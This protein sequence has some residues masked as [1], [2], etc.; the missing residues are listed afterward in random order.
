MSTALD[1]MTDL[2]NRWYNRLASELLADPSVAQLIQP[3]PLLEQEDTSLWPYENLIPPESLTFNTRMTNSAR[4]FEEYAAVIQALQFP[5]DAFEKDIGT[6]VYQQWTVHLSQI[7][8]PPTEDQLPGLFFEWALFNAP[9]VANIGQSDLNLML[10]ISAA[11]DAL[12]PYL[13]SQANPADFTGSFQDLVNTLQQAGST[14]FIFDSSRASNDVSQTWT[15]G[16]NANFYGLLSRSDGNSQL[17]VKFAR[18]NVTVNVSLRYAVWVSMPGSWYSSFM[19]SLALNN[20][21]SPPWPQTGP[22]TWD[23][24]FGTQG[25]M[26]RLIG[27]LLVADELNVVVKS[28]AIY[29]GFDQRIVVENA[30]NGLWPFFV[31]DNDRL[32]HNAVTFDNAGTMRVE[33]S[34]A[35]GMP[36]VIGANVLD[37]ARY[38]GR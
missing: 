2:Q 31:P 9:N 5:Q 21:L 38:L 28:D 14:Q 6:S 35:P 7:Q 37:I 34:T 36:V 25:S 29:S 3:S 11:K 15:N 4:F 20:K 19:L 22:P 16:A 24:I 32:T 18:S 10:T 23:E 17:T 13:G 33:T 1:P 12:E 30:L 26:P 8:P 27:S